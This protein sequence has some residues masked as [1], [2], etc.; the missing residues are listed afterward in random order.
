[1][2]SKERDGERVMAGSVRAIPNAVEAPTFARLLQSSYCPPSLACKTKCGQRKDLSE[3]D[4]SR[5]P[6]V[7]INGFIYIAK[8]LNQSNNHLSNT[9]KHFQRPKTYVEY[10]TSYLFASTNWLRIGRGPLAGAEPHTSRR[11]ACACCRE[12][13]PG[14]KVGMQCMCG[15]HAM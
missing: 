13:A 15:E 6:L 2:S 5:L 10:G 14:N 4:R 9:A 8:E 3:L 11:K 1:M 12:S 7:V